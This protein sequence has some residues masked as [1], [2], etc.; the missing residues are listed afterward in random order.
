MV[1]SRRPVCRPCRILH[2]EPAIT[3]IQTGN[4]IPGRPCLGSWIAY[5]LGSMNSNLPTFVVLHA[6]HS[7]SRANVQ[8]I[9]G[10]LWTSGFLSPQYVGVALRASGDP[11]L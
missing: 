9:S 6:S 5:G 2:H 10:K 3:F 7:D 4:Q 8:A 1:R 11:V